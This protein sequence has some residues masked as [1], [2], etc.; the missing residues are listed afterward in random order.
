MRAGA[1]GAIGLLLAYEGV[2]LVIRLGPDIPRLDETTIDP[3]V[4]IFSVVL[5]LG[6]ALI[7]GIAPALQGS[8]ADLQDSLKESGSRLTIGSTRA[9]AR[10]V[11]VVAEMALALMLLAGAG[12]LVRSFLLVQ[13]VD[14]GFNP[15]NLL[16]A[17]VI[18]PPSKYPEPWRQAQFFHELTDRIAS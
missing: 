12:L 9:R 11:L 8:R 4:L 6:T 13:Q 1:G 18:L 10:S 2:D 14:P 3:Q 5:T 15:K 7:F 16:T 17:F